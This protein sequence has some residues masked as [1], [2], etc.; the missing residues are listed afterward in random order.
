MALAAIDQRLPV[1]DPKALN[2]ALGYDN[3]GQASGTE[4]VPE[5]RQIWLQQ[6][7]WRRNIPSGLSRYA[8]GCH[9]R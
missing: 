1:S 8:A 3:L 2:V 5:Y 9:Q 4:T 6:L 7:R